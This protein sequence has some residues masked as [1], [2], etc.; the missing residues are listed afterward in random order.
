LHLSQKLPISIC[1]MLGK[2]DVDN[3]PVN[4]FLSYV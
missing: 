3:S 4:I 2:L 1:P